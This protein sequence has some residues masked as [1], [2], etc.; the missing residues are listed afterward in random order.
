MNTLPT[1][2]EVAQLME[3]V[4]P[5]KSLRRLGEIHRWVNKPKNISLRDMLKRHTASKSVKKF[6]F[7]NTYLL[8]GVA[9]KIGCKYGFPLNRWTVKEKISIGAK[10]DLQ[11]RAREL[12]EKL[13]KN[14]Y[15]FIALCETFNDKEINEI[16]KAWKNK[17]IPISVAQGPSEVKTL[18]L[19]LS[20]NLIP[21]LVHIPSPLDIACPPIP[22]PIPIPIPPL[23]SGIPTIEGKTENSGLMTIAVKN[24][25]SQV[26]KHA[27]KNK[28]NALQDADYWA[29]K[30]VL[31]TVINV[32]FGNIELYNT[33]IHAGGGLEIEGQNSVSVEERNQ[34]RNAQFREL[35]L[36]IQKNKDPKNIAIL[37]G[38]FN[39]N[40]SNPTDSQYLIMKKEFEKV[41]L[42]DLWLQRAYDSSGNIVQGS[43]SMDED[44]DGRVSL[45]KG[46]NICDLQ[47]DFCSDNKKQKDTSRSRIDYIFIEKPKASHSFNLDVTRPRRVNFKRNNPREGMDYLSDHLGLAIHLIPSP[48]T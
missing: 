44:E 3:P 19:K 4:L 16:T 42:E 47:G 36:F 18:S 39:R 34:V 37:V 12:G 48:K 14:G 23:I 10:P 31:R 2:R 11:R 46:E 5:D 45:A 9:L 43:T 30:G 8:S 21:G 24:T 15:D 7:Y 40:G 28:G 29:S 35:R 6:L 13:L 41:G 26:S 38:D 22:N 1:T 17:N 27:Y 33:H 25:F 32:G 20:P